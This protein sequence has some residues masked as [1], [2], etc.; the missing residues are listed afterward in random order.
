MPLIVLLVYPQTLWQHVPA[1]R[2]PAIVH[3]SRDGDGPACGGFLT[4]GGHALAIADC[5]RD[6]GQHLMVLI[7]P[8]TNRSQVA[9]PL[10][11]R[12]LDPKFA[13]L[14]SYLTDCHG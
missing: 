5:V 8:Y 14:L 12:A 10:Q 13:T 6:L 3:I 9:H 1:E 4:R 11:A 2:Y 7:N